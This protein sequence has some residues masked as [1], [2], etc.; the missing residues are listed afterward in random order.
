MDVGARLPDS[1]GQAADAVS[2]D[3]QVKFGGRSQ[4]AQNSKVRMSRRMDTTPMAQI[5]V[6]H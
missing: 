6:K 5:V 3:T 4:I 2:A 1:D